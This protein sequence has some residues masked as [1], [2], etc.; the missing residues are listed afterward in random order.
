M[1]CMCSHQD[2]LSWSSGPYCLW[3][4]HINL[5]Q[6]VCFMHAAVIILGSSRTENASGT[7][8]GCLCDQD[9]TCAQMSRIMCRHA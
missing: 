1:A 2:L 8:K 7:Y 9:M 3:G 6:L 4:Q 5:P